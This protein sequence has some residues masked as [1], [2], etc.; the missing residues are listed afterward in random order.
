VKDVERRLAKLEAAD[1]ARGVREVVDLD[2]E[3]HAYID[4]L[5]H[6]H[7]SRWTEEE[8][9]TMAPF[10]PAGVDLWKWVED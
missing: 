4:R 10:A 3:M 9:R 8:R 6:T 1:R 5:M 2:P 7:L